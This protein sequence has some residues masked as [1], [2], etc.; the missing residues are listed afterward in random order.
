MIH[1]GRARARLSGEEV[2]LNGSHSRVSSQN[3]HKL[4][5]FPDLS[6]SIND[7]KSQC[8]PFAVC[9]ADIKQHRS[10]Q[11]QTELPWLET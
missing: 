4:R 9:N 10:S 8:R 1:V 11:Q 6:A 5:V 7:V 2:L 3:M